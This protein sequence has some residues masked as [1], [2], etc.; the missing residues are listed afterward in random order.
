MALISMRHFDKYMTT[1]RNGK[2]DS[3]IFQIDFLKQI[4][5]VDVFVNWKYSSEIKFIYEPRLLAIP[6]LVSYPLGYLCVW[7]PDENH[8]F[9]IFV[10]LYGSLLE[11]LMQSYTLT[12]LEPWIF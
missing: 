7:L 6:G 8:P 10:C 1:C 5:Y 3:L 2:Q 4:R 12:P 9:S 11:R